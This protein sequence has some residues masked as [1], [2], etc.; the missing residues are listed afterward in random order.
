[1]AGYLCFI[2]SV[3]GQK[4]VINMTTVTDTTQ[5]SGGY[6]AQASSDFINTVNQPTLQDLFA[7]PLSA[8]MQQMWL[9]GFAPPIFYYLLSWA[10]Q[11]LV[12]MFQR[13]NTH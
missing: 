1:M 7:Y 2:P 12:D 3:S 13:D 9:I 10:Y 5:C 8:D 11:T 4:T 6:I